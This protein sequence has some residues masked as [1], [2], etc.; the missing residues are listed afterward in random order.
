MLIAIIV[1]FEVTNQLQ[2]LLLTLIVDIIGRVFVCSLERFLS[3]QFVHCSAP[4][5]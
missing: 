4:I 1:A 3:E 2:N 5:V